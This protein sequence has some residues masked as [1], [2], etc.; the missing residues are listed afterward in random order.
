[1]VLRI[2]NGNLTRRKGMEKDIVHWIAKLL[3]YLEV[4]GRITDKDG[5]IWVNGE[6]GDRMPVPCIVMNAGAENEKLIDPGVTVNAFA[7]IAAGLTQEQKAQIAFGLGLR[8][9]QNVRSPDAGDLV[10][11]SDE[12]F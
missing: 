5:N 9:V 2:I 6:D 3:Q 8:K 7:R 1:M 11:S 10:S 12:S 4:G